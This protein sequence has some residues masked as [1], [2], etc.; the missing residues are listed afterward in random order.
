MS[1]PVPVVN[2]EAIT[3]KQELL[4]QELLIRLQQLLTEGVPEEKIESEMAKI[5][6]WARYDFIDMREMTMDK[7]LR[8]YYEHLKIDKINPCNYHNTCT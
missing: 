4:K 1:V 5:Q 6:E 7:L 8:Y 2:E 3:Q